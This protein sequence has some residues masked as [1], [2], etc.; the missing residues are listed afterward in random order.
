MKFS[1]ACLTA[2]FGQ[3]VGFENEAQKQGRT[4]SPLVRKN[5]R[6]L[7]KNMHSYPSSFLKF[8]ETS[9]Y[10][11]MLHRS[12]LRN[13]SK[14]IQNE[15]VADDADDGN[16]SDA[17]VTTGSVNT[18]TT[19][20]NSG[21]GGGGGDKTFSFGS[22]HQVHYYDTN[23]EAEAN[24]KGIVIE[25]TDPTL[26]TTGAATSTDAGTD[27]ST[28]ASTDVGGGDKSFSFGSFSQVYYYDTND[29]AEANVKGIVIESI[30]P[31]LAATSAATS[32]DAG[33]DDSTDDST[34]VGGGD[35]SFRFG[36]LPQVHYYN[37]NDEAAANVEGIVTEIVDTTLASS[38]A[39]TGAASG[40]SFGT[41]LGVSLGTLL[42]ALLGT[43][44]GVLLGTSLGAPLG[45][46]LDDLLGTSLGA[47]L[48]ASLG[49]S[50]GTSLG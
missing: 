31:T 39:T 11:N 40:K 10:E 20:S 9:R 34:V 43:S 25:S 21:G 32:T 17:M 48:G 42:G 23:D 44:L 30:D 45:T 46:S 15:L 47:L 26:A 22:F 18:A 24:M 6:S 38:G 29:E 8:R 27:A 37:A 28:N 36:S 50:L 3:V 49:V 2:L 12:E 7:K 4:V 5:L 13:E 14:R 19:S 1:I 16:E 33:T 35:K 41:S